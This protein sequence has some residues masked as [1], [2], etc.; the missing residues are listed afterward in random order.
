MQLCLIAS[1]KT[2]KSDGGL[3]LLSHCNTSGDWTKLLQSQNIVVS[4]W[5]EH[6]S[7]PKR[8]EL[9]RMSL[10][11]GVSLQADEAILRVA[12]LQQAVQ[13]SHEPTEA[14]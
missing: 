11:L 13:K 4:P 3:L 10:F 8:E 14:L 2:W 7:L 1:V 6:C 9:V 5:T 12:D